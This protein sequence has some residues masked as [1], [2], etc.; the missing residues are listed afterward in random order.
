M[1]TKQRKE[2]FSQAFVQ[3]IAACAGFAWS[4][5]SVDEDSVD[6]MLSKKGGSGTLRSP[7]L[8]L[9]L[10][11]TEKE[12]MIASDGTFSYSIPLKNYDDLRDTSL[13]IPRIL[14]VVFVPAQQEE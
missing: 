10:K 2:Q 3:A 1:D 8:E 4:K 5:P 9:Q 12:A 11:C 7:R 13:H 14:V 6:M